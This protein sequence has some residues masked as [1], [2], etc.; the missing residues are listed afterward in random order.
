MEFTAASERT[1]QQ[2]RNDLLNEKRK[3][4]NQLKKEKR[5]KQRQEQDELELEFENADDVEEEEEDE[6]E[7]EEEEEEEVK[8]DS[9]TMTMEDVINVHKSQLEAMQLPSSLWPMLITK[10][11]QQ[12]MDAGS[13]FGYSYD[14]SQPKHLRYD[15][16]ALKACTKEQDVWIVPHIWSFP[17]EAFAVEALTTSKETVERMAILMGREELL[18][19]SKNDPMKREEVAEKLMSELQRYAYPLFDS[20]GQRYYYVM[21]E[22]GSRIRMNTTLEETSALNTTFGVIQSLIDGFTY[23]VFWLHED[24]PLNG[25]LRRAPQHRLSLLGKGKAAW[26]TRFEYET[27]YDWYGGWDDGKL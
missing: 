26:E 27:A 8:Q 5:D 7:E 21:D 25:T 3:A 4:A 23:T 13:C 14:E 17:D 15:V 12:I 6:E 24:V 16:H 9:N 19:S 1:A 10:L 20:E 11:A 18:V 22:F 2:Q